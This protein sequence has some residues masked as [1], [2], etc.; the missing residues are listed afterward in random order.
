MPVSVTSKAMTD[1]VLL[2]IGWSADQPVAALRHGKPDLAL[3]GKFE[4]VREKI[5]ESC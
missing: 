3:L 1:S 4:G 5:L 2:R